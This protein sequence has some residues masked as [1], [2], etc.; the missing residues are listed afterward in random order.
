[1]PHGTQLAGRNPTSFRTLFQGDNCRENHK[2]QHNKTTMK[3][4]L[5]M[6]MLVVAAVSASAK[7]LMGTRPL[8]KC[9]NTYD[10]A[11]GTNFESVRRT[12][13]AAITARHLLWKKGSADTG[14]ALNG[15]A[16]VPLGTIDN[17]ETSTGIG[18]TVLLLGKGPTK[19]MVASEAITAGEQ[20]FTAA[21]GKVQ[22]LPG[23]TATVYLVGTAL[24]AAGA[25]G[26]IIEVADCLPVKTV[27]A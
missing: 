14:V 6:V 17:T 11:V 1:M 12:N 20:V 10:A 2:K 9:A 25:D 16:D 26:D 19:K 8:I 22:D 15:V 5:K 23:S 27:I 13:D 3:T 18:N 21:N 4:L 24:T 7:E